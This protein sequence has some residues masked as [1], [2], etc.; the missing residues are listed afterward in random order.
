MNFQHCQFG[1]DPFAYA[2]ILKTNGN[3]DFKH[4]R[5]VP[6]LLKYDEAIGILTHFQHMGDLRKELSVL[7]CNRSNA[8]YKLE[9]WPEAFISAESSIQLDE[10]YIKGYYRAG[11][12]L[13]KLKDVNNA[14]MIFFRGLLILRGTSDKEEI[15][16]FLTGIFMALEVGGVNHA[17]VMTFESVLRERYSEQIWKLVIERLVN[18][19]KWQSC[20]FLTAKRDWLPKGIHDVHVSLKAIFEMYVNS[21]LYSNMKSIA[22]LVSWLISIGAN[23]ETIGEYPLHS[24]MNLCTKAV[25][26]NLLKYVINNKPGMKERINQPD[27]NG[28]T[29]LHVVALTPTS[30]TGYTA[31]CQAQDIKM[32]LDFGGNPCIGDRQGRCAPDILKR[33]KNFK[34]EDIIKKHL[35][36]QVPPT[37]NSTEPAGKRDTASPVNEAASLLSA[38]A[39]FTDF[40]KLERSQPD[41]LTNF[42]KHKKVKGF[43]HLLSKLKE[44]PPDMSCDIPESFAEGLITQLL[45]QHRWN[46]VLLLLTGNANGETPESGK[47]LLERCPLPNVNI[48]NVVSHLGPGMDFRLP[49]VKFLLEQGV[50]PDGIGAVGEAPIHTCLK[51][52]DYAVAYL[53]LE[54]G[55]NPQCVSTKVGDTPLHAAVFIAVNKKDDN[56]IWIMKHLLDLYSSGPSEYPYLDPNIQDK[57][58]D[59]V[60][61][62]LF[63]SENAK[64][65]RKIMELLA[66]FDIK[67]TLKNKLGKDAKHR[68]KNTDLRLI[69]WNEIRK[70]PKRDLSSALVKHVPIVENGNAILHKLQTMSPSTVALPDKPKCNKSIS[71]DVLRLSEKPTDECQCEYVEGPKK[72][73]TLREN[74]VQT[75]RDLIECMELS[76]TPTKTNLLRPLQSVTMDST[77]AENDE[78]SQVCSSDTTTQS[79]DLYEGKAAMINHATAIAGNEVIVLGN[80]GEEGEVMD[81]DIDLSKVDFNNMTWEIECAPEALKKLESKAVPQ[82]MKNK[83]ILSVQKL[84]NG[85]WTNSVSKRLKHLKCDIKLYEVKLDKG[86]RMLWELA[87]D[88]SPR[89]SEEPEHIMSNEHSSRSS[90]KSGRVYTEIIRIWDIVLDHC[91]LNNAIEGICCAYNRGLTCI[92]RKKL[93]GISKAQLSSNIEKRIPRC[94]VEDIELERN[95]NYAIPDY[96]PP[97][98]AA[99]TEYNIMKFHSFSTDM[100]LNIVSNMNS[101]VEYPFIVGEL[102]YA[103]I[104]LHPKPMETIIL[105][106]RSGTGKTTCCLYRLWKQFHSYWE[107]AESVGG[108][109]FV[110]QT[111]Q[112]RKFEDPVEKDDI[113][114]EETAETEISDSTDEEQV[115]LERE[116]STA[117]AKLPESDEREEESIKLEHYHPIFITK[118]HVLCQ[119]VQRNFLELSKST[120]A[121]SHFKPVEPNIYRLQELQDENFPMFVTSQQLLLLL[122][123]SMPDPFFLRNEDGSLKRSIIG[124]STLDELDI[125]DLLREDDE[126]D[127]DPENEEDN[128]CDPKENDPRIFVTF[129]V[130]AKEL[131]PKMVKGKPLYNA[132]LVWKEIKSFL[133]GSFEA[134]SCHQGRLTKEEYI[135]LGKK[136]APNFQEDRGEIYRLFCLYEQIK[137]KKGY[138]DEEDV[139]YNLSCRLSK[140]EE[141]PWSIHELYG[142]EI[143]DFTQAELFLLMRCIDDPNAMFLTGDTAQSIM[144][145]VSF[146]FSDLR[147]LFHYASKNCTSDKKNCVV[148]K[149]KRIYQLYQNY[150]SHSG[151]LYLAS[152]VVDLLQH[153]FPESFDRLPRDCG[154]FGGPKPTVLESCCV[155]DLAIL[156]RG[157]KRKTQPIEFGAHQVILVT[158]ETA[159][160]KIPEELSLALV[161]TIYEAKGLEFDDVLL[162]NFFTDSEAGKEWKIISSFN[163]VFHSNQEKQ[164]LIE[165]PLD[166]AYT[167]AS[168]PL[169]LNPEMHK[170]LNGELKQLYTAITRARV[171]LWIF[172]EN[173]EK[174]APAFEYFIKGHFVEVVRTDENKDLDDNMFVKASTKEEWISQGDYYAKHQC[175]KVAAKCYQ[176]GGASDKEKLAFAHD[177]VLNV[178]SKKCSPREKQM[179]YMNLAK[180]Y[181]ECREPKLALKCLTFSK[182][183]HLCAELCRKLEKIKE[184]AY[185]YKRIQ[186]YRIAAKC[187]E[188]VGEFELALNLYCQEKMY[189]EAAEVIERHK[190]RNP[191]VQLPYTAEQFYLEAAA[192]YFRDNKLEKMNEILSKLDTEDQLIFLKTRKRWSD[193]ADL[194][195]SKGRYEEAA[196]LMRQQGRLLEAAKL[197]KKKEF[198]ASCLLAAARSSVAKHEDNEDLHAVV[199]EAVQLCEETE[200]RVGSA[201]A[202]LLQGI[203]SG[204]FKKLKSSFEAFRS[205]SHNAGVVEALFESVRCDESHVS[206]IYMASL[207]I[208]YLVNLAKALKET[209]NNAEREM[210]KSCFDFLGVM[211]TDGNQCSIPQYEGPRIFLDITEENFE[212]KEK[213]NKDKIYC[214]EL[215][216]VKLLLE[217]HLLKR[218]CFISEKVL[219]KIYPEICPKFI[220]GLNCADEN[221][222]DFHRPVL[223]QELI[224][225]LKIKNLLVTISGLLFQARNVFSKELSKELREIVSCNAYR[226]CNSFLNVVFPKHFHLRILSENTT[227]CKEFREMRNKFSKSCKDMLNEY[228]ESL[229]VEETTRMRRES[230]DLWLKAMHIFT[231][232]SRY[233]EG[234]DGFLGKEERLFQREFVNK[235]KVN[236]GRADGKRIKGIEGRFGMLLPDVSSG[237]GKDTHISFFR[238]L[239]SAVDHLY[240]HRNPDNCKRF[241]F[242]FLNVLVKKCVVPLI[243]NIGN[244]VM[245]LEFQFVL[246][247]AVVMRLCQGTRVCLPKSYISILHHWEFM[248]GRKRTKSLVKDTYSILLDYKP[249]DVN[250]AAGS[251]RYH[252][253]YLTKVLCGEEN[254]EFNVLL[255]AFNDIDCIASGEAE[256]TVVLCLVMMVNVEGVLDGKAK[257]IL[258]R[259]FPLIQERLKNFKEH[260]PSRVPERL[261]NVVD[262]ITEDINIEEVVDCLQDLLIQRDD[263]HLVQCSWRWDINYGKVSVRGIFYDEKFVRV[264]HPVQN[265]KVPYMN[266][267]QEDFLE[268]RDDPMVALASQVQQKHSAMRQFDELLLLVCFCIKWK[269]AWRLQMKKNQMELEECIPDTFKR[270][271]V[272]RTQCDIC[273]VK[274][275]QHLTSFSAPLEEFGPGTPE[276][277]TPTMNGVAECDGIET[278]EDQECSE[279]YE[280]HLTLE[281]HRHQFR[282]YHNY[283]QFY[284]LNVDLVLCDGKCLMQTM[285]QT[286][287]DQLASKE[288]FYLLQKKIENKIK[289]VADLMENI[290]EKKTWTEAEGLMDTPVKDLT[291]SI[292]EAQELLKKSERHKA[293]TEGLSKEDVFENEMEDRYAGFEEL[294]NKKAKRRKKTT[295]RR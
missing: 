286:T 139:L 113:E 23:V 41:Q 99:E 109:W 133:K 157:N 53:L 293:K 166:N 68:I 58:G 70:K 284:K 270:A 128:A 44:I 228:A 127:A 257:S 229:F 146:R 288:Q 201:E 43:L 87:I 218:L 159:K 90:E 281:K 188:Q 220:V 60:M 263:E 89:C 295:K 266:Y 114:D 108:P 268:E 231:L 262:K 111:W 280:S 117:E 116:C 275:S 227:V 156:L 237:S 151:I 100:A 3:V 72:P 107:K 183:F 82:F 170:M 236:E 17:F 243:P 211:K 224:S 149:P 241:F 204:D 64:Q 46:E 246:C 1:M 190:K 134:L 225:I 37:S 132:A 259:H 42:S 47:G 276:P 172:D 215:A 244:A 30:S 239:Q 154:L 251:F 212:F 83:I 277:L 28:S 206:L 5:Y 62:M 164:P 118:N 65:Y 31:K 13:L 91:K 223:R 77:E 256:R 59:T 15:T 106:G 287:G 271:D 110:K 22:D 95:I 112:R 148:R 267:D 19:C 75:I 176:K 196:L 258:C 180:T 142:D 67:L 103:V 27:G 169:T 14:L 129:E 124:W 209:K 50:S 143:Q 252:L 217:K 240:V 126:G 205:L 216:D 219:G 186:D 115:S 96:F 97:A 9:K 84:G 69:A 85:E 192:D 25:E 71:A 49:L 121:T 260:F 253:M 81:E 285:E 39:Q 167:S 289:V 208:E 145:G 54:K 141:L 200:N 147:S 123:A 137:S 98:S 51:K 26:S 55:G 203:V 198:Q 232:S 179:E 274:F 269:R 38:L 194:L 210:V 63:R 12:S 104:D 242:R 66:K 125:P 29:L 294:R 76:K 105:I 178:Q 48:G 16:E 158:N 8:F 74:L 199:M 155:S 20:L 173:Q 120:K 80:N 138:F 153:Y 184:A 73:M 32:L 290:Y 102:E 21:G 248:F 213:K 234:L 182:E 4:G 56:G 273:G 78:N 291:T 11:V 101:R 249:K 230:T 7:L 36:S 57:N 88:F 161:L 40:C 175:W 163:P 279:T 233:P 160:E 152:G 292:C 33:N 119:E 174:R 265:V 189:E 168:R 222:Q 254:K 45:E 79:K 135:K 165:V 283:L 272:D 185:F 18:R 61:H 35:A 86:A 181:L 255:D 214:L 10:F 171:N 226:I 130:F 250:R 6:A 144:K 92:L 282:S 187:F 245:L 202:S 162:Y 247:C 193:A 34:A 24:I 94:F 235:R 122:D 177:A 207:G 191:D 2:E 264:Q 238:L 278:N 93:K 221:C 150:R 195:Q 140:L 261:V 131:W 52:N 136:R 197:T